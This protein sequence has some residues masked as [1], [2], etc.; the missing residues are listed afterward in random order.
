MTA[1]IYEL[2]FSNGARY[3]GKSINIET[4]WKQHFDKLRKG[5]AARPMQA[6]FNAYGAPDGDIMLECHPDH[7]DI[8]EAVF[9]AR[10][11]PELNTERPADPFPGVDIDWYVKNTNLLAMSTLDHMNDLINLNKR[12]IERGTSI[13]ELTEEIQELEELNNELLKLRDKE[14]L[15][16]DISGKIKVLTS[17]VF[18]KQQEVHEHA[19]NIANLKTQ[20]AYH[21]KPWWKKIF[22]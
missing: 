5:T 16:K 20:I 7:I 12:Y 8:M 4:R 22:S 19:R 10:H 11:K 2:K 18:L 9:I 15:E 17:E 3:I 14:A 13:N 6:A 1:G 21:N